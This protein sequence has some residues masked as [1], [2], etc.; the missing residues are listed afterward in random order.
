MLQLCE[1]L[2]SCQKRLPPQSDDNDVDKGGTLDGRELTVPQ[3]VSE[4]LLRQAEERIE[5]H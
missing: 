1:Q 2:V 3:L 5:V 4:D